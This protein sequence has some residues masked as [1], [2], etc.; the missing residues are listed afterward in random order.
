[1]NVV[2]W[3]NMSKDG[4][5]PAFSLESPLRGAGRPP[6]GSM[7]LTHDHPEGTRVKL[8]TGIV[9]STLQSVGR[10]LCYVLGCVR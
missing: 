5:G 10:E 2:L 7:L 8:T 4:I 1:M 6:D 9:H 3:P